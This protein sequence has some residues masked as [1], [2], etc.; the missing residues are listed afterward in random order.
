MEEGQ[1]RFPGPNV[2]E[3]ASPACD[4]G[5]QNGVYG[6]LLSQLDSESLSEKEPA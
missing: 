6:V 2:P 3:P 5:K 1:L 4:S